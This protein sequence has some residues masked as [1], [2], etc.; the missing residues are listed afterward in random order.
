MNDPVHLAAMEKF[1]Q[2]LLYLSGDDYTKFARDTYAAER[3]TMVR[4]GATQKP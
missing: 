2:D 4:L 3:E 1:D